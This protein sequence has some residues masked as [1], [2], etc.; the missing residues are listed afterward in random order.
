M[1]YKIKFA[2]LVW[3]PR[4]SDVASLLSLLPHVSSTPEALLPA[5]LCIFVC[6]VP[7]ADGVPGLSGYF[8]EPFLIGLVDGPSYPSFL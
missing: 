7:S 5:Q 6:A 4:P 3:F 8:L 1:A 2:F